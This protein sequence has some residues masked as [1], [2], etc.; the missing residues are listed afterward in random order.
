MRRRAAEASIRPTRFIRGADIRY[1]QEMLG[2]ASQNG[3]RETELMTLKISPQQEQKLQ[4]YLEANSPNAPGAPQY[5]MVANSCV[6]VT[7]NALIRTGTIPPPQSQNPQVAGLKP[8]GTTASVTPQGV[9]QNVGNAGLIGTTTT[10]GKPA[11][12]GFFRTLT[13]KIKDVF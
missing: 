11:N 10:V 12:P 1:V 7:D 8:P 5:N 3:H 4:Q 2:H 9:V 6:T 13:D